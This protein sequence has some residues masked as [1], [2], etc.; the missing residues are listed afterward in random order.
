MMNI[1]DFQVL[2]VECSGCGNFW[3][4]ARGSYVPICPDCK[5]ENAWK[6]EVT[7]MSLKNFDE[8]RFKHIEELKKRA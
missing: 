8:K 2:V 7:T 4:V 1:E 5:I 6:L 3:E